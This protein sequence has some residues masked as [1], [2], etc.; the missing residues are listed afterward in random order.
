MGH[1][2]ALGGVCQ[3]G[4]LSEGL[5]GDRVSR[6][7]RRRGLLTRLYLV[8]WL[9]RMCLRTQLGEL[10]FDAGCRRHFDTWPK[11]K[12]SRLREVVWAAC[13]CRCVWHAVNT[14]AEAG[15]TVRCVMRCV[16]GRV[17]IWRVAP[18]VIVSRIHCV[19]YLLP[20]LLPRP[21]SLVC[22]V[23]RP[24]PPNCAHVSSSGQEARRHHERRPAAEGEQ[25]RSA[26]Q[27]RH[28]PPPSPFPCL[29]S[30][31]LCSD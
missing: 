24:P 3:G 26:G 13:R 20:T 2:A 28:A 31:A 19:T 23:C 25:C 16:A 17:C 8:R 27:A 4:Q 29:L 15:H 18:Y 5:R 30:R 10:S 12:T 7:C 6:R 21:C 1:V 9:T 11:Y 22:C 14:L